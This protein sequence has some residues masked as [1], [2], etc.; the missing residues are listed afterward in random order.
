MKDLIRYMEQPTVIDV[1]CGIRLVDSV[2]DPA[3]P[4]DNTGRGLKS[5]CPQGWDDMETTWLD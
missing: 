5:D 4:P 1:A 3:P 2:P